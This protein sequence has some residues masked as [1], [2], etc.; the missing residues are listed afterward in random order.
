MNPSGRL[1][2]SAA[3]QPDELESETRQELTAV[4]TDVALLRAQG[5]PAEYLG[6]LRRAALFYPVF[7]GVGSPVDAWI[8]E[9]EPLS[10]ALQEGSTLAFLSIRRAV[11]AMRRGDLAA[12]SAHLDRTD[13]AAAHVGP[14]QNAWRAITR[15]RL[16][17][18]QRDLEGARAVLRGAPAV[19]DDDWLASLRLVAEGELRIEEGRIDEAR[20]AL[21]RAWEGLPP[22]L[23]EERIATAQLLGF[24]ATAQ[25]DAP[26]AL[27]WLETAR[28]LLR[29]AGAWMEVIQMDVA[30]GAL[31][32]VAGDQAEAQRLF[33]EALELS[34]THPSPPIEVLARLGLARSQAAS[35]KAGGAVP[36]AL[37]VATMHAQRGNLVGYVAMIVF[38]A[39]LYSRDG[40]DKEAYRTLATGLAIANKR[41]WTPVIQVMRAHIDRLRDSVLGPERFDEMARAL[42]AEQK[43]GAPS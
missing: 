29:A 37:Q 20:E 16:L 15:A 17:T 14:T 42:I 3:Q 10:R 5:T 8:D 28:L 23:V 35:G 9:A 1:Q 6:A 27:R 41:G 36:A 24:A 21:L 11:V 31:R 34:E 38:I 2:D 22:D 26:S 12:A 25:A 13:D 39:N 19:E 7:P 33:A 40:D 30:V 4:L 32:T 18:R 43:R